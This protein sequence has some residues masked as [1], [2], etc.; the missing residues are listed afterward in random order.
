ML[1]TSVEFLG[2]DF[3]NYYWI[4]NSVGASKW[5]TELIP[6][7]KGGKIGKIGVSNHSPSEIKQ[8]NEILQA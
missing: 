7:T 2:T 6:L 1:D 8:T 4:H 5:I 3:M